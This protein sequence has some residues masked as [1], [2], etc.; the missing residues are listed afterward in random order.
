MIKI[1]KMITIALLSV[2]VLPAMMSCNS[3]D[4]AYTPTYEEV[5]YVSLNGTWRLS[6]WKGQTVGTT[7]TDPYVYITFNRKEHTF[8]M[9]ENTGSMYSHRTTGTFEVAEENGQS[10]LRGEYD[11]SGV[12]WGDYIVTEMTSESMKWTRKGQPGDVSVY[13]RVSGVPE[14]VQAGSR[15][16]PATAE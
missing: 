8:E 5:N 9:Y 15:S 12:E 1:K 13:V 3:D 10:V 16:I 7:A 2:S 6:E 14:D 4:E 11:Y